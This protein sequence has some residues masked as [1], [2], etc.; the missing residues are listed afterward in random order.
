MGQLMKLSRNSILKKF[1]FQY[2]LGTLLVFC[3]LMQTADAHKKKY[4][5]FATLAPEGSAWMAEMHRLDKEVRKATQ[6]EV[7]FKFY[8]GGVSGSWFT[9]STSCIRRPSVST[10]SFNVGCPAWPR[11]RARLRREA[12]N[13]VTPTDR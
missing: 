12:F 2:L 10:R 1:L 5:K 9:C 6:G 8:A 3:F 13:V 11:L 7:A 4:I